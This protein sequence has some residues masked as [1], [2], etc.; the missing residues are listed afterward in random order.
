MAS[1][2]EVSSPQ[3][4]YPLI[5]EVAQTSEVADDETTLTAQTGLDPETDSE[6]SG[7]KPKSIKRVSFLTPTKRIINL[8]MCDRSLWLAQVH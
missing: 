8:Y 4:E 7:F 2:Q 1:L 3:E 6:F 5:K